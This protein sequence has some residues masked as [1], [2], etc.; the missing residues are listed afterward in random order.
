[1]FMIKFG[2]VF[3]ILFRLLVIFFC[4]YVDVFVLSCFNI[5]SIGVGFFLNL[6]IVCF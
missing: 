5:G 2:C 1:M 6:D 4:I 3:E